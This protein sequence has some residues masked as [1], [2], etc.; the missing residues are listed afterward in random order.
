MHCVTDSTR[1]ALGLF[2]VT[3]QTTRN[4]A[5]SWAPGMTKINRVNVNEIGPL[6]DSCD[7]NFTP[8]Y[9]IDLRNKK[10]NKLISLITTIYTKSEDL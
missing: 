1:V 3:S 2:E 9:W 4:I 8:S 6:N 7:T 10:M 5:F